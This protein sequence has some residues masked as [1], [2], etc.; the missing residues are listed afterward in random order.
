[1]AN[2]VKESVENSGMKCVGMYDPFGNGDYKEFSDITENVDAIIDF[3]HFSLTNKILEY[4]ISIRKPVVIATTGHTDEQKNEIKEASK[5]IAILKA[6]NTSLGVNIMNEIVAY[7]TRLLVDFDIELIEKHHNRKI[8]APS[9]T[10]IT[11][12]ETINSSLSDK[13]SYI[14]GREGNNKRG[15]NEIGVHSI[16]AGNIVGEHSII[17]SNG[18]E[19]IEIKHEALSRRIFSDGAV[20][21]V[22]FLVNKNNGYYGMRDVLNIK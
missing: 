5:K 8:D 4:A 12:L 16:R 21:A 7:A 1:M 22:L 13:K 15:N 11:L 3:S 9:G 6:T 19:V 2:F 14:Y 17:Y 10:A 18:D 20:K